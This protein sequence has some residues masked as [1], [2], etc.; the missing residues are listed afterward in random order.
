[1]VDQTKNA[2]R[3]SIKKANVERLHKYVGDIY[4][5]MNQLYGMIQTTTV[6][7]K[8]VVIAIEILMEKGVLTQEDINA[9]R[10]AIAEKAKAATPEAATPEAANGQTPG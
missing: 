6:I 8:D 4:T 9:K 7:V 3:R 2:N 10:Q 1:M 5:K